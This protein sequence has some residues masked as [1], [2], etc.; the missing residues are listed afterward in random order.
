MRIPDHYVR[1]IQLP[2]AVRGVTLPNDDG[3]FSIYINALYGT[4]ARRA[5][6]EHELEHLA[7][8]HFYREAPVA[9]LEAEARREAPAAP[10]LR[11][12]PSLRALEDYLR[13]IGALDRPL[14]E[15]GRPL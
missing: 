3:S 14:E 4:R 7:R 9:V 1:V 15:L 12:Y 13:S 6:L 11:C 2:P 8:D 5:A 10:A